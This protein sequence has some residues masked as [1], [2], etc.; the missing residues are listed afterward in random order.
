MVHFQ[1]AAKKEAYV[2]SNDPIKVWM[3]PSLEI[4]CG[5]GSIEYSYPSEKI[6]PGRAKLKMEKG[7]GMEREET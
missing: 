6:H 5:C 7:G 3:Y 4:P 1:F 2:T